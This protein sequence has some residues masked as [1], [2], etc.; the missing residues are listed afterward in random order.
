[1]WHTVTQCN[2]LSSQSHS[3]D[4]QALLSVW[5]Q[6][7]NAP[8]NGQSQAACTLEFSTVPLYKTMCFFHKGFF[9]VQVCYGN[10]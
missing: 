1:M 9:Y 6:A 8:M 3:K 4:I 2:Y 5:P 10:K 7:S